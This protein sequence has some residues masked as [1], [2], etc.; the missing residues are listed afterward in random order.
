MTEVCEPH[1]HTILHIYI[2]THHRDNSVLLLLMPQLLTSCPRTMRTIYWLHLNNPIAAAAYALAHY[3]PPPLLLSTL[4]SRKS[5]NSEW[6]SE[7]RGWLSAVWSRA[8][9]LLWPVYAQH[10]YLISQKETGPTRV[11][12]PSRHMQIEIIYTILPLVKQ[13]P[14]QNWK[15]AI[16]LTKRWKFQIISHSQGTKRFNSYFP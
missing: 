11:L 5:D 14:Y 16:F 1:I 12:H 10:S 4:S 9:R 8:F 3:S 7:K 2:Q 6:E 15:R 13:R